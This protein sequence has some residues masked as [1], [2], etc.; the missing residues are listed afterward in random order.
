M[1]K[2]KCYFE[3]EKKEKYGYLLN[4]N[5]CPYAGIVSDDLTLTYCHFNNELYR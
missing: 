4:Y 3:K 5:C 1:K 2:Q